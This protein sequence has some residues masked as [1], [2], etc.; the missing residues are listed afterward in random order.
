MCHQ[1]QH[2]VMLCS[3]GYD[4]TFNPASCLLSSGLT[5]PTLELTLVFPKVTWQSHVPNSR[6]Y[7]QTWRAKTRSRKQTISVLGPL[8]A[9]A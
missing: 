7:I 4:R 1:A 6:S 2:S 3:P 9:S 8:P 5:V